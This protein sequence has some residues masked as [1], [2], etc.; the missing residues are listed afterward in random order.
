MAHYRIE[1]ELG[2]GGQAV[3]FL[4]EDTRLARRVALKVFTATFAGDEAA[5]ARFRREAEVASRLDDPAICAVYDADVVGPTPYIAMRLVP[6]RTL[7]AWIDEARSARRRSRRDSSV[8]LPRRTSSGARVSRLEAAIELIET[9]ARALHVAHEAGLVHR[10]I[11]PGNVMVTPDGV[12]VVLDFGLAREQDAGHTL[13]EDGAV[14]GTPAYMSPEQLLSARNRVDRRTDVYSLG[15]VL[16]EC[17]TLEVPFDAETHQAL[18]QSILSDEPTPP[19]R[20]NSGLSRDLEIVT[21]NALHKDRERRYAT[22][23]EFADDLRRVLDHQPIHARRTPWIVR[24]RHWVARHPARATAIAAGLAVALVTVGVRSSF[25]GDL[26]RFDDERVLNELI[27]TADSS[28]FHDPGAL[29][30]MRVWM[31]ECDAV[32]ART[33]GHREALAA[34][35]AGASEREEPSAATKALRGSLER[36]LSAADRLAAEPDGLR[37]RIER[38]IERERTIRG[39]TTGTNAALWNETIA[40]IADP[41]STPRYNGL[42]ISPQRGLVPLGPDPRSGLH[43]FAAVASGEVPDR[44]PETGRLVL[45]DEVAIVLILVPGGLCWIGAQSEDEAEPNYD[46]L[47]RPEEAPVVQSELAPYF[48][49]KH[50]CTQAQ[51]RRLTWGGH[52]VSTVWT[53]RRVTRLRRG[54]TRS[55]ASPGPPRT[56]GCV[57]TS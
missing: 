47:A 21:L 5:R 46:P 6:G 57:G 29:A 38:R 10:D 24:M 3:V 11:K 18:F 33:P 20:R 2:R 34:I 23:A 49:A 13:T 14:V 43:E 54:R 28:L 7:R 55:S 50:E 19:R 53:R 9:V 35:E 17:L 36:I 16:Y 12:P 30:R 1:A 41:T 40:A 32:L 25:Q 37:S 39:A 8:D 22:A 27:A 4:A 52:R 56:P 45:D 48:L 15:V 31:D 26:S 42:R 44:D 51:W